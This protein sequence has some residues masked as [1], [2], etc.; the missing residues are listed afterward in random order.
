MARPERCA[1]CRQ[2]HSREIASLGLAHLALAPLRP[3][4][5]EGLRPGELGGL[6]RSQRIH[7]LKAHEPGFDLQKFGIKDSHIREFCGLSQRHQVMVV[8]AP[9][10]SGKSTFFP[11]RL[12]VPPTGIS[13]DLFTCNGQIIVTQPRIQATRNIPAFVARQLHG[14]SLGAGFD[15]GFQHSGNPATDWR[16]TLVYMTDG[17]LI[18]MI[19]RNEIG[20]L[21]VIL[22]DEA[23]ERSLN[24]DLILGLLKA[25]LQRY[26]RLKVII[27]SATIDTRLFL[28]YY[29]APSDVDPDRYKTM[30]NDGEHYDN[31][32]IAQALRA[33]PVGFYGFPGTRQYP[34]SVRFRRQKPIP[35]EHM[36]DRMPEE[37]AQKVVDILNGIRSGTEPDGDI[38]AFLHGKKPIERAVARIRELLEE[39][40]DSWLAGKVDVLPLYTQLPQHQQDIALKPR[41][42]QTRFRVIV[43]T[44]V[45]E[46]SLTVDGIVHVVDT[47]LI[48]EAQWDP[49]SQTSIVLPRIHSQAGCQQRWGR[50]GRIRPGVAH[51]LYSEEQFAQFPAYTDPEIVRAPLE[52]I[53][54]TAKAAGVSDLKT[55][56]WIQR[57][58]E[59]ELE[60]V[61]P[62]LQAIGALDAD[63]DLTDHGM[64]L[65]NFS[66]E[67]DIANLMILAD[68][69][70]CAVEMATLLPMCKLGGYTRLLVWD[71][72]WDA[73]TKRAV[74]RIHQGLMGLCHDDLEF[75]LKLWVAW[76]GRLFGRNTTKERKAWAKHHFVRY[77]VLKNQIL[78][79]RA[80]LLRALSSHKKDEY[81]RPIDFQL[82]TRLRIL[83]TSG[84]PHQLYTIANAHVSAANT[85]EVPI[86]QPFVHHTLTSPAHARLDEHAMVGISPESVCFRQ[87]LKLFVCGNRWRSRKRDSPLSEPTTFLSATFVTVINPNWL[88]C[89]G[90]SPL[91]L[92]RFMAT[93]TRD[94]QGTLL[95]SASPVRLF[96]DQ[97][98]P[99]GATFACTR[100]RNG[101]L[102]IGKLSANAAK[103]RTGQ[104]YEHIEIADEIDVL[105]AEGALS[106]ALGDDETPIT[107]ASDEEQTLVELAFARAAEESAIVERDTVAV[108]GLSLSGENQ[109]IDVPGRLMH[110]ADGATGAALHAVV[111]GYELTDQGDPSVLLDA[112]TTPSPFERFTKTLQ[113]KEGD[114]IDVVIESIEEY[115]NDGLLYLV[116]REVKSGL[117]LILD[118]YDISLAGRNVGIELLRQCP[119]GTRLRVTI[120]EINRAA[121]SVRATRLKAVLAAHK[122]FLGKMRRAVVDAQIVEVS[123]YGLYLWLNPDQGQNDV[124]VTAFVGL[125]RLPQRP[126]EMSIGKR[127]RVEVQ[128]RKFQKPLRVRVALHHG[129]SRAYDSLKHHLGTNWHDDGAFL[130]TDRPLSYERRRDILAL[131]A[132]ADYRYKV[133]MLFRR[134]HAFDVQVLD[135]TGM[136]KLRPYQEQNQPLPATVVDVFDRH[137]VIRTQDGFET[138]IPKNEVV[139]DQN[140]SLYMA[141]KIHQNVLVRVKHLNIEQ[142]KVSLSMLDPEQH[143]LLAFV[144]RIGQVVEGLVIKTLPHNA[145]VELAPGAI[146]SIPLRELSWAHVDQVTDILHEDQLVN[147]LI[148]SVDTKKNRAA[149]TMCMPEHD[150]LRKYEIGQR[151]TGTVVGFAQ[152]GFGAIVQVE[153]GVKGYLGRDEIATTPVSDARQVLSDGASVLVRIIELNRDQRTMRLTMRGLYETRLLVPET[154]RRMV[155]GKNGSVIQAIS[156]NTGAFIN[157]NDD[158]W[159]ILQAPN[160]QAVVL[161]EQRIRQVLEARIVT[162]TLDER[163]PG[164]LIGKGGETIKRIIKTTGAEI[165]VQD[166][167]VTVTAAN[168][169]I[170]KQALSEIR[171]AICYCVLTIWVPAGRASRVIGP[172]G[173]TI[174]MIK[175]Q[176]GAEKID[177]ERDVNDRFTGRITIEATS[178]SAADRTHQFIRTQTG[179]STL[180]KAEDGT[181]PP[182]ME[183]RSAPSAKP[184]TPAS[185]MPPRGPSH[186]QH[187]KQQAAQPA[188][189]ASSFLLSEPPSHTRDIHVTPNQ[190]ATLLKPQQGLFSTLFGGGKS[191]LQKIQNATSAQIEVDPDNHMLRITAPTETI[192]DH[193]IQ[194]LIEAVK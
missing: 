129:D 160:E 16:N 171:A 43:A 92:A 179:G 165:D 74:R 50:S 105:D 60:R 131:L 120:E 62:L 175:A 126:A 137:V 153:P 156:Q 27:A 9:T 170:L 93:K 80:M 55:F 107:F 145:L 167:Q 116:V 70:G 192:I 111:V 53:V 128:A 73:P 23:H 124:P 5:P 85:Y 35:L 118:P 83:M 157:L 150:P 141:L 161:A 99:V 181:M 133:N 100:M 166:Q 8:V 108:P 98:Y 64:E 172:N 140:Q 113:Y 65:R 154:H 182:I 146:G 48:N 82:L 36:A 54:L 32:A 163:Q 63:G 144:P 147:V 183:R 58:S 10:G 132:E 135:M 68:R 38:L 49:Q 130:V 26:P 91:N 186:D 76:E 52:H 115:V 178:R 180:L 7:E 158:G 18:N 59:R 61:P 117:E 125:D 24:I 29:G 33:S 56:D 119:Q 22:I 14:S 11:Y 138:Q 42:D 174:K 102:Q 142:G 95:T 162:F 127:C 30:A 187:P 72:G 169:H 34:V 184:P 89:I 15:V 84:L 194:M 6:I 25:Q 37:V 149:L 2:Q 109:Q 173:N 12:M 94:H 155:I 47:G 66:E 88:A 168:S 122:A 4:P 143:P 121:Q 177:I 77:D 71:R 112:K 1:S 45:A 136:K 40:P 13:S 185:S 190:L 78:D 51:C 176:G 101:R 110:A 164:M 134:S 188:H 79:E 151:V 21:S 189:K 106:E 86:Y 96:I 114:D 19:V 139:Y 103:L 41:K 67:T 28:R 44:N 46:T 148:Q 97:L 87:P 90:M 3:L 69:F 57:P 20:R 159:C 104:T 75:C 81:I 123:E 193:V 152:H 31:A 17:S 39:G 191:P